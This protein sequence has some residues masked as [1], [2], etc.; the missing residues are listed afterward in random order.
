[1]DERRPPLT[2]QSAV[3]D[4]QEE[5]R[6]PREGEERQRL[7]GLCEPLGQVAI[8]EQVQAEKGG[9]GRQGPAGTRE[10]MKPLEDQEGQQ[11]RPDL[12]PQGILGRSE[13]G[14][15]LQV[16]LQGLAE[17]LDLPAVTV[18]RR[19]RRGAEVEVVMITGRPQD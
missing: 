6:D 13:E 10:M 19:D 16:L 12:D 15:R 18:D 9:E 1:M 14:P 4:R 2:R 8:S 3:Q 7:E 17:E 5:A 11:G